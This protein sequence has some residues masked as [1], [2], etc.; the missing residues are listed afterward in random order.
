M[1]K[2]VAAF[3]VL[4][5]MSIGSPAM[6]ADH[7]PSFKDVPGSH[8]AAS[9][10]RMAVEQGYVSGYPDG[11]F[12]PN[13]NVTRAEFMRMLADALKLPHS[14]GGSPWYQPYVAALL[15]IGVHQEKDF[16]EYNTPISRLEMSRLIARGLALQNGYTQL[17]AKF[18]YLTWDDLS[19]ADRS[20]VA[21]ADVPFVALAYG[22]EILSGYPD[23][24]FRPG[25]NATRAEA[26]VML[27]KLEGANQ[28]AADAFSRIKEL[29]AA[30]EGKGAPLKDQVSVSG[31]LAEVLKAIERDPGQ[32]PV[33]EARSL[34]I[35][36]ENLE[37]EKGVTRLQASRILARALALD[38]VYSSYLQSFKTLY[39]GDIPVV[40][41]KELQQQDVPY[42]ALV[43][44][45]L[46]FERNEEDASYG[47]GKRLVESELAGLMDRFRAARTKRPDEF[48][49]M[50]ELKEVA[51]TGTNARTLTDLTVLFNL[52]EN[53]IVVEHMHH[54]STLKRVY[55]LP[56][57]GDVVSMYEKKFLWSREPLGSPAYYFE[58]FAD[59]LIVGV[60]DAYFKVTNGG[61]GTNT[62]ISPY[63]S[64]PSE[65]MDRFGLH[66]A[67]SYKYVPVVEGERREIIL[68][69]RFNKE[70]DGR[71]SLQVHNSIRKYDSSLFSY[72][73]YYR[74]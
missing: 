30:A 8:W 26:V 33:A 12:K 69:G 43:F 3:L 14:Q 54:I 28:R 61:Y 59:A 71:I 65:A 17:L 68:T 52:Q 13:Q 50:R 40:D 57:T 64:F 56:M 11:T 72:E 48:Q 73:A 16:S 6:A 27:T 39:N 45:S 36:Q 42:V 41:W 63:A 53:P 9:A 18:S 23:E 34:G 4:A 5:I 21:A 62:M 32:D 25:Q 66:Y 19:F 37:E 46:V 70:R 10:I 31:F 44:G 1:R 58:G 47:F 38:S 49:Y 7:A 2:F 67:G 15:E 55:V 20:D 22:T 24:T 60:A 51:E 35:Y 29:E 74:R